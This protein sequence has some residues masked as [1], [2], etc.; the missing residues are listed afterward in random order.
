VVVELWLYLQQHRKAAVLVA[1][2]ALMAAIGMVAAM[3]AA[4]ES[5]VSAAQ[6]N[7]LARYEYTSPD[8]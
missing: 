4:Q 1:E 6:L 7:S 8:I 2:A 3:A 5:A